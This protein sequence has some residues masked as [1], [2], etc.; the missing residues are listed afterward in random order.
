MSTVNMIYLNLFTS[1]G[2]FN[3]TKDNHLDKWSD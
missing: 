3:D 1:F 2:Y